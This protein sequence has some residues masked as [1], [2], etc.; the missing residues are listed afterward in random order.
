MMTR[1]G[2]EAAASQ[3]GFA[4]T[5]VRRIGAYFES[6][7]AGPGVAGD[8]PVTPGEAAR[9]FLYGVT[10]PTARKVDMAQLPLGGMDIAMA[11]QGVATPVV[12]MDGDQA[13]GH[14]VVGQWVAPNLEEAVR[15]A[16]ALGVG[17]CSRSLPEAAIAAAPNFW[18]LAIGQEGLGALVIMDFVPAPVFGVPVPAYC[19]VVSYGFGVVSP[20]AEYMGT[21][22]MKI[23]AFAYAIGDRNNTD[24]EVR[25][26][27]ELIAQADAQV[28]VKH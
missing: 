15:N 18:K 1:S 19:P 10:P 23:A 6:H 8:T 16:F 22:L 2:I 21:D 17:L 13:R 9:A 11:I 7:P 12:H 25:Q 24:P 20:A 26:W 28:S 4:E 14:A 3:S 5:V 27:R